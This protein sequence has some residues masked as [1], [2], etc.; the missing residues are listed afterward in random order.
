MLTVG[1]YLSSFA[2]AAVVFGLGL[3]F[4]PILDRKNTF[5]RII[6]LGT[7]LFFAWRYIAWRFTTTIP[8]F[9]LGFEALIAWAF[10]I[11]EA[12]TVL[13]SS[14]AAIILMR[15]RDR[16]HEADENQRWWG[17][18]PEP[19]IDV[20]IA[21]YNEELSVLERTIIG[22]KAMSGPQIRI[23][24]LDDG[25]REWLREACEHLGVEWRIR[26]DN[27]HAKAGNINYT[28]RQRLQD[29]DPPDFIAVLDADFVPH[30]NFV[31]RAVALFH[32]P[33]VGLVQT[34][35]H[36]FNP[37]PVQHNLGIST[38]Y[39]DEQRF[40]FDHIESSRDAWGIAVCAGT[41]SMVRVQAISEI[42][43]FP[44]ESVTEDFLL[45]L[46]LDEHGWRSV[47][48]NE[49]LTEGLAPE[50]LQEYIVQRGRWCL[51]LM[52]IVRN[53]YPPFGSS[54]L[55]TMHRIGILDSL[56]YWTSTFWF[57]IATLIVPLLYWYAGIAVVN[58]RV[59]DVVLYYVPYFF[60]ILLGFNW[61]ARGVI[62]PVLNDV[63]Q[64]V[65]A[66]PISRAAVMGLVSKGPHRFSV[67]AKGG[68]RTRVVVQWPL[69]F[70]F[71]A[72]FALTL[73][74][75]IAGIIDPGRFSY[76][77]VAGDGMRVILFWTLYNLLL[78]GLAMLVC[79]E[80]PR[81]DRPQREF[82]EAAEMIVGEQRTPVWITDLGVAQARVRGTNDFSIGQSAIVDIVDIGSVSAHIIDATSDGYRLQ[83]EPTEAQRI[84]LL[85][86]LH[87]GDHVPGT[88][89]GSLT[90]MLKQ[91]ARRWKV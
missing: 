50:G 25:R 3:L 29:S 1:E 79:I 23:F 13:S 71:A 21:T 2:L 58:A 82:V 70:P 44:T 36:F 24:I 19:R 59:T 48:L 62:F 88:S 16:S 60:A 63:A 86:K 47:Y 27:F 43:G 75:L 28:L 49:A 6:V 14:L 34:P 10:A 87:T 18:G 15:T 64:L 30:R 90:M 33:K 22:A 42:G 91:T 77:H 56:L 72:F 17:D 67:T 66:W 68:D 52:Q 69:L 5:A 4:L 61:L 41:S 7:T 74:G 20:Y 11:L 54:N 53:V 32:D 9:S 80:R 76:D 65:G 73:G 26:P 37:D 55:S 57:R 51:G 12:S 40:F 83:L 39:P 8:D 31:S 84:S 81:E 85:N 45:T 38:G 78:L 89:E 35:Q 46:R